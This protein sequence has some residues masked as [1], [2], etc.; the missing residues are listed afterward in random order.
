MKS[1]VTAVALGDGTNS[2]AVTFKLVLKV[3]GLKQGC[4]E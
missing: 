2:G 4:D 1:R 3:Q